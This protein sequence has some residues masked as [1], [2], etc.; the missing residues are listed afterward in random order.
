MIGQEKATDKDLD[1]S[2]EVVESFSESALNDVLDLE[3]K[4]VP[5]DWQ[6]DDAREYFSDCLKNQKSINLFL[7]EGEK[8]V[9]YLLAVPHNFSRNEII[10][11]DP[12]MQEDEKR[13]YIETIEILPEARGKGG[14]KKLFSRLIEE[15]AKKCIKTFSAHVRTTNGLSDSVKR[16]FDG[17][18]TKTRKIDSWH[19]GGNEPYEYLEWEI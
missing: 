15:A 18:I 7:K 8:V 12:L 19:Y 13:L 17:K 2:V 14:S 9:G 16:M 10:K 11:Y 4:C 5:E 6:F 3:K 1:Q